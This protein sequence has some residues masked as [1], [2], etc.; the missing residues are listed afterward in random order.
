MKKSKMG[1]RQLEIILNSIA[2]GVFTIDLKKN[3][4]SFN[5][6]AE[7]ITGI[8][9]EQAIGQKC[10]DVFHASICQSA[11][12]IDKTM[13]TGKQIIDLPL[14]I[15]NSSG[16]TTPISISTA[17]LK[18]AAGKVIGG[19]ETFRDL[20]AFEEM[21]KEIEKQ[22]V[23]SD[24]VSKNHEIKKLFEIIP[25]IAESD[26]TV[27]IQG[28]SGSGKELFARAIH[29]HSNRK[30]GPYIA[31]NCSALPDT[32]LESELFGYVKGA[33][34]DAKKNKPG[35][36]ALAKN[37]T[38]FLDEIGDLSAALQVK[39]LRVLQ[40]RE[41]EP[42]GSTRPV[43]SNARII[44]A[45]NRDLNLLL[46]Q[47]RL[48]EDFYYRINVIKINLP[49]LSKRREDIPLLVEHFVN[50]FNLKQ[51]K[52]IA[53]ISDEVMEFFMEYDF[54][55]N[56]RELENIIEHSFVLCRDSLIT[57][58]H[59][60]TDLQKTYKDKKTMSSDSS[61]RLQ[62]AEKKI[63]LHAL[64]KY[65]GNRKKT[66]AELNINASTLWR[67]MKKLGIFYEA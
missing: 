64:N 4:T 61:S 31:I 52:K 35:R 53:G 28:P 40:E 47:G 56:I 60:S 55:G 33:F 8:P 18:N 20:S 19:V 39:L 65:H 36:F 2:D 17:V 1:N 32:L 21:R 9:G 58:D 12:A 54:N 30:S 11:C 26:S 3:I 62:E 22:Y 23:Y 48:R 34:T 66:A 5:R 42:L 59:L 29:N 16:K 37:G 46:S 67:K 43:K 25:D 45:T 44:T 10:F 41:Y 27:L 63:I 15:L 13:K 14:N 24:I 50:K 38:L 57:M 51:N 7:K 6:A 49:P